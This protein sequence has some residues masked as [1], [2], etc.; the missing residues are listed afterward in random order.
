MVVLSLQIHVR[1]CVPRFEQ[2]SEARVKS[3][4]LSGR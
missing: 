2:A 1:P 4:A 3:E